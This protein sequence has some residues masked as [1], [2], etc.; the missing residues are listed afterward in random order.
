MENQI[1]IIIKRKIIRNHINSAKPSILVISIPTITNEII[2]INIFANLERLG[3]IEKIIKFK[4]PTKINKPN[5]ISAK[6]PIA[7]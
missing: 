3:K 5:K 1:R 7:G 4:S 6:D 2:L